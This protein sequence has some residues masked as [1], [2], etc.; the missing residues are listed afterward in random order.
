M[1]GA[2]V[3]KGLESCVL[4][5]LL[6]GFG[7]INGLLQQDCREAVRLWGAQV[8]L[9]VCGMGEEEENGEETAGRWGRREQLSA[10]EAARSC[11]FAGAMTIHSADS[12]D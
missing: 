5:L 12:D 8:E 6:L 9:G 2:D 11:R 4:V 10:L 1:L 3:L 7:D